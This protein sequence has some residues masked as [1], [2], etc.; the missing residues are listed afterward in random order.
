LRGFRRLAAATA[1]GTVLLIV[2]GA[3]VRAT[4]SGLG[5]PDWPK[6]HGSWIPPFEAASLIEYAH[7][8]MAAIVGI[9][10]L[11]LA[12][13]AWSRYRS[14]RYLFWPS[15]AA[16]A[17]VVVQGGIGRV[18]VERELESRL[19]ALHFG[20]SLTL[21]ALLTVIAVNS[22][23]PRR[24]SFEGLA[25]LGAA[26]AVAV[27]VVLMMGA[28]VTQWGAALVF[29]D[30]PLMGGSVF[31]PLEPAG[32][33]V[34]VLHRL[35]AALLGV[36]VIWAAVRATREKPR[37][38]AVVSLAHA[39]AVLWAAQVGLG[40]ANVLTGSAPWAVVLHVA[41]GAVLW[42]T[43]VGFAAV[44]YRKAGVGFRPEEPSA[45]GR[46]LTERVG[47]YFLLTKPRIIEL[48]LITTVP[49]MI[50][51]EGGWP[52]ATLILATL[53]GGSLT[54]GSANAINC[55]L[56]R[57]IDARM[58]R[59]AARPLPRHQI[60]PVNALEF[61]LALGAIGFVWLLLTVNSLAA[62]LALGA[63]AFY[64]LVYTMWLKRSGPSNIVIG[65][66]AGAAP[67]LVGW[68]AVTGDLTVEAL[69]MFGI[70]FYWT[71]PHFWALALKYSD[72]YRRA[73]VPM[74]PV[75]RGSS[76]TTRQML[77]YT[78]SLTALALVL[79]PAAEMGVIYLGVAVALSVFLTRSVWRLHRS[80]DPNVAMETFRY[81][82]VYLTVL[83]AAIAVDRL[84]GAIPIPHTQGVVAITAAGIFSVAQAALIASAVAGRRELGS[85]PAA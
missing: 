26:T 81:S 37:D 5:C 19:V 59:T 53:I 3:V 55:Y 14:V 85:R 73:E 34:H 9:L 51:A 72:D 18:V 36:V 80:P 35:A 76:H 28:L 39:T 67:V 57:D 33:A 4:G 63:V 12:I 83:F 65:G 10:V 48:L 24:G 6:C 13:A 44:S 45:G 1:G 41:L 47:A 16:L 29:P 25:P 52:S 38:R 61:G 62:S 30:W 82:I 49:A 58:K 22:Y 17:L 66:A 70:V 74:L 40:A 7:R 2:I 21:L 60:E 43:A 77:V 69:V 42:V 20:I 8:L 78:A 31:P 71:P 68:A 56:D 54:A 46:R 84:V 23:L 75:V 64:V 32:N 27:A 11:A 79:Y 15:L 50:L